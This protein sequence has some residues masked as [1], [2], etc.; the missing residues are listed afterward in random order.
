GRKRFLRDYYGLVSVELLDDAKGKYP[1]AVTA[2]E[3]FEQKKKYYELDKLKDEKN[4]PLILTDEE[5]LNIINI[6]YTMSLT[7]YQKYEN[8]TVA[9]YVSDETVADISE[10]M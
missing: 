5:A 10:H 1:S 9:S 4:N 3:I 2:R 8:T 6:R 7:A